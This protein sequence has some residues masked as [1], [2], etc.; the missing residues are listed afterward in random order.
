MRV[1]ICELPDDRAGFERAWN[2]LA[3]HVSSERSSL[4]IL[5]ELPFAS[6]PF[7]SPAFDERRWKAVCEA[8]ALESQ[9]RSSCLSPAAIVATRPTE[10]ACGRV[11]EAFARDLEGEH[12]LHQKRYLPNEEGGWEAS[13]YTSGDGR[14]D[15]AV[16]SGASV[17]VL[18]CSEL[19]F[20]ERARAY[21][22]AGAHLVLC[23]RATV[24]SSVDRW[25]VGG[26]AAAIVAGA[27]CLSSNRVG[28][29]PGGLVFGGVGFAV[30]P[31]GDVLATTSEDCPFVTID[32]DL[33][34][35]E[36]A[37]GTY[38]RYIDG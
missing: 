18:V 1:T 11:N 2:E 24:A 14:F 6:W 19:W 32:V 13:W 33:A 26:R 25:I 21:G 28:A 8:H 20:L 17:G 38:P 27:Y 15:T 30:D 4:V 5:P 37:R 16:V 36:R 31:E 7:G 35:A 22:R 3:R 10:R 9:V 12:P 29:A 34:L 23:P